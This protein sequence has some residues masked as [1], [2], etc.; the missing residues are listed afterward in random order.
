MTGP[1]PT[2]APTGEPAEGSPAEL[3]LEGDAVQGYVDL[4]TRAIARA[5]LSE[6]Y[7]PAR[8]LVGQVEAMGPRVHGGLYADLRVDRRS[9]LPTYREW[10]RVR[11]DA[12]LSPRVLAELPPRPELE[13]RARQEP[14]GIWGKQ[15]L[16]HGY[17]THLSAIDATPPSHMTVQLR[18]IEPLE[19]RAW[20]HVVLDKLDH[21][22]V[23]VRASIELSQQASFWN[24]PMLELDADA[25]RFTET[26]RTIVYRLTSLDAELTFV[27][28]ADTEGLVVERVI[29]GTVG[30]IYVAGTLV[31][32]TLAAELPAPPGPDFLVATFGLDMAA[33]DLA[34]DGD[35]D[36]LEDL[37]SERLAPEGRAAYLAARRR[38]GYRVYKDR[39]LVAGSAATGD[40]VQK[41]CTRMGTRN[42]I[43]VLRGGGRA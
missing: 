29:R 33:G 17:H 34:K 20:F 4:V 26:L 36:P 27:R 43:Y 14:A 19:R 7:P 10:T 16:K 18:R 35:N 24:R 31:P 38:F 22:G 30:P 5:R 11:A 3:V 25:A 23:F 8:R 12:E 15:L 28:L 39:K 21:D 32:P 2:R 42:V 37:L 41:L 40:A 1:E 13:A 9:G 6:H